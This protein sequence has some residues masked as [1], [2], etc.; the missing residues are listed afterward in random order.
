[1][2][3]SNK[4][5]RIIL[6]NPQFIQEIIDQ[7][8][9]DY[10]EN[11]IIAKP[12]IS[13]NEKIIKRNKNYPLKKFNDVVEKEEIIDKIFNETNDHTMMYRNSFLT[14]SS[15]A[16]IILNKLYKTEI[17]INDID[18]FYY[19]WND[20]QNGH[21]AYES[22]YEHIG[23][24]TYTLIESKEIDK[25]NLVKIIPGEMFSWNWLLD[26]FDLN[27]SQVGI[28]L[29]SKKIFYTPAFIKFLKTKIIETTDFFENEDFIFTTL[30]RGKIKEKEWGVRFFL[31]NHFL[32]YYKEDIRLLLVENKTKIKASQ[33]IND[34]YKNK[35]HFISKKRWDQ[36]KKNPKLLMPFAEVIDEDHFEIKILDYP[37]FSFYKRV[38]LELNKYPQL[39]PLDGVEYFLRSISKIDDLYFQNSSFFEKLYMTLLLENDVRAWNEFLEK[40]FDKMKSVLKKDFSFKNCHKIFY[41]LRDHEQIS[42]YNKLLIKY[43]NYSIKDIFEF[44]HFLRKQDIEVIGKLESFSLVLSSIDFQNSRERYSLA[45][46]SSKINKAVQ[47]P[48]SLSELIESKSWKDIPNL[49]KKFDEEDIVFD[50]L[51]DQPLLIKPFSRIV[52]EILTKTSLKEEG[53]F[54]HHCVGGYDL[55]LKAQISRIFHINV[56]KEHS[57]LEICI[58]QKKKSNKNI[59]NIFYIKQHKG[60]FNKEP[61]SLNKKIAI[62]LI[63]FLNNYNQ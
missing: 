61:S 32:N 3:F 40:Y 4:T 44:Y 36:W 41:F 27:Y 47:R 59:F 55:K 62:R 51:I 11:S 57:T 7:L 48:L 18:I 26:S 1:M 10:R 22:Q 24:G 30:I 8:L 54:M 25:L 13:F 5:I 52:T 45:Q 56:G 53:K 19:E 12:R 43:F 60:F 35:N 63:S 31:D 50:K 16:S 34:C 39:L 21:D 58:E 42:L 9:F 33:D 23:N 49:F 17:V 28:D 38:E 14:G 2:S 29:H 15:V 20:C 37:F 6:E 46:K